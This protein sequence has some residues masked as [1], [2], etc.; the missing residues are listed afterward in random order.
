MVYYTYTRN[1]VKFG[2]I[3]MKNKL[4][5][6]LLISLITISC[7]GSSFLAYNRYPEMSEKERWAAID[8]I[9]ELDETWKQETIAGLRNDEPYQIF[10]LTNAQA[11]VEDYSESCAIA[12]LCK[13]STSKGWLPDVIDHRSV[14]LLVNEYHWFGQYVDILRS[15]GYTDVDYSPAINESLKHGELTKEQAD[16]LL[17]GGSITNINVKAE[18]E[19][20]KGGKLAEWAEWMECNKI[21]PDTPTVT[22]ATLPANVSNVSV[23]DISAVMYTTNGAALYSEAD[24]TKLFMSGIAAKTPVKVTGITDNGFYRVSIADVTYYIP[25]SQLVKN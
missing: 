5:K 4:V 10:E 9:E 3:V 1:T 24:T 11:F 20:Q 13:G 15:S 16:I 18:F 7:L 22:A 25:G 23:K 12:C 17:A 21:T 2:G 6:M 14:Q 8:Q 19:K